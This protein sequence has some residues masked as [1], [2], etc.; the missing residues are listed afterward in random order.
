MEDFFKFNIKAYAYKEF[1]TSAIIITA[2][3]T[4]AI[5]KYIKKCANAVDSLSVSGRFRFSLSISLF[6]IYYMKIMAS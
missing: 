2:N 5:L 6:H 3:A 1:L 4:N